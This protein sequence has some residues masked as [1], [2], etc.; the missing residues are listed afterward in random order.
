MGRW[1][2]QYVRHNKIKKKKRKKCIMALLLSNEVHD[3]I[4]RFCENHLLCCDGGGSDECQVKGTM[5]GV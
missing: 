2:E 1:K 3:E 4:I 5:Q